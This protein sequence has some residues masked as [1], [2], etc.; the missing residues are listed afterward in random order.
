MLGAVYVYTGRLCSGVGSII[1][2]IGLTINGSPVK[3]M[4]H[5]DKLSA[6]RV[7]SPTFRADTLV[8]NE[9]ALEEEM[10]V[11]FIER[12]A[13]TRSRKRFRC[14]QKERIREWGGNPQLDFHYEECHATDI[15]LLFGRSLPTTYCRIEW[16][17]LST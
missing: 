1:V 12:S 4:K 16:P 17:K 3:W 9:K 5:L 6:H 15:Y 7:V 2:D 10:W 11:N 14:I 13:R 8:E